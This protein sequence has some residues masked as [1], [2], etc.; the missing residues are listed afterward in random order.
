MNKEGFLA[1]PEQRVSDALRSDGKRRLS[2]HGD[3]IS[4]QSRAHQKNNRALREGMDKLCEQASRKAG[5]AGGR[6]VPYGRCSRSG[7]HT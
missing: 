1:T 3:Y 5:I 4:H 6:Q 2:M 7:R